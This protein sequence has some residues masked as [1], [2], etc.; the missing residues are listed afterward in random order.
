MASAPQD[1]AARC[2]HRCGNH[3]RLRA[4]RLPARCRCIAAALGDIPALEAETQASPESVR[5]W[6]ALGLAH[7]IAEQ[8]QQSAEAYKHAVLLSQGDPHAILQ[9]ARALIFAAQGTV[10]AEASRA[11]DMV[12]LQDPEQPEARYFK[13]IADLQSGRTQEAM[14]AMKSLYRDLPDDSPL[15]KM[16]NRQIGRE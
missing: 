4:A 12:L 9:Y 6:S 11:L 8:Y 15:K 10:T 7:L 3:T 16:I 14:A 5:A 2:L 13:A 1:A